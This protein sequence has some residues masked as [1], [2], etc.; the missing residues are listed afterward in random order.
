MLRVVMYVRRPKFLILSDK[1]NSK[2]R[3]YKPKSDLSTICIVA[4]CY[5]DIPE[6]LPEIPNSPGWPRTH[7]SQ[8]PLPQHNNLESSFGLTEWCLNSSHREESFYAHRETHDEG[9]TA[10][11]GLQDNKKMRHKAV[12]SFG[13]EWIQTDGP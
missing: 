2:P 10:S 3:I 9:I 12:S 13:C 4:V 1:H 11:S 7:L 6:I 8:P 5:I